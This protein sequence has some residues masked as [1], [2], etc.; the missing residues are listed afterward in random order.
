M[1]KMQQMQKCNKCNKCK[2]ATKVKMRQ[3]P[4]NQ[5]L[6][7]LKTILI[8]GDEFPMLCPIFVIGLKV[9]HFRLKDAVRRPKVAFVAKMH[10]SDE[11]FCRISY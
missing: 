2:N 9:F 4:I 10:N 6:A 7:R 8:I 11:K 1:A 5:K 3:M